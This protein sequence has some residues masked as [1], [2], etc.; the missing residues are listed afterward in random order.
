MLILSSIAIDPKLS[1]GGVWAPYMGGEF[2]LARKGPAFQARVGE[3]YTENREVIDSKDGNGLMTP[4]AVHMMQ[5]IHTRAFC[6]HILLDW[7]N[8][9][10]KDSGEI[11]YT[12][13]I[14][15][16]LLMN[17]LYSELANYLEN[18]SANHFYYRAASN[19]EVAKVVKSSA[20]S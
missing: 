15:T 9:G 1:S 16:Q 6:E 8:V 5:E 7:K 20:V 14:G 17:P 2:L 12:P 10:E 13:E 3:L 18:F 19:L 4:E 11:K